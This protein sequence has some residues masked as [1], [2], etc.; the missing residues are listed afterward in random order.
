MN[1]DPRTVAGRQEP[2]VD[3]ALIKVGIPEDAARIIGATPSVRLAWLASAGGV[4]L[5]ALWGP[6]GDQRVLNVVLLLAPVLPL[7]GVAAAY[8]PWADPMF[9]V[10]QAS[11]SSGLRVLLLRAI[12][13]LLA[14]GVIVGAASLALPDASAL[15]ITWVLPALALCS[16]SLMLATFIPLARAAWLVGVGWVA[17]VIA[18][19][20]SSL[21]ADVVRG[22]VQLAFFAITVASS[23]V[24]A[25]RRHHL[26]IANLRTRRS[27][28]DAAEAERRRIERNI[29]DGAQQ[30]LVSIGVKAG[31]AR[32][33]IARDPGRAIEIIDQ[34]R[35]EAQDALDSLRDMAR[36]SYP[37]VLADHGLAAALMTKFRS[38]V[39][40]VVIEADRLGRLPEQIEIAVYYCC[41]EAIQNAEKHADASMISVTLRA[42]AGELTV[43]IADDG[44]GF[45]PQ[46]SPRGVGMRSMRERIEALGGTLEVR[47]SPG[48]GTAVAAVLPVAPML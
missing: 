15:A 3:R 7:V 32:T 20:V 38:G 25:R 19:Q 4:A 26:E 36:G 17:L 11:P 8:G 35:A 39:V 21:D 6:H 27:L 24:V 9:D 37:P 16:S 13:V 46:A 48:A 10:T 12:A 1:A 23:I 30:Q 41:C 22:R 47:S 2:T 43:R 42:V 18:A 29:H 45:D 5:F 34:V 14:A 33:L 31:L 28:L 44:T 40:P